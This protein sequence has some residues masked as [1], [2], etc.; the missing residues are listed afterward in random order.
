LKRIPVAAALAVFL[1]L[2]ARASWVSDDAFI[3]LRTVDNTLHGYG[4]RWNVDERVQVFTHPLWFL[5][6]THVCAVIPD[7]Y[8]AALAAGMAATLA[9][10]AVLARRFASRDAAIAAGL[11]GALALSR[12]F[13]DFSTSGLENP[14]THLLI[15]LFAMVAL[16]EGAWD[17]K[18][19]A[20]A[21]LLAGLLATNRMDALLIVAPTLVLR[22]WEARRQRPAAVVIAGF[23]PFLIWEAFAV[24]YY[25]SPWPNPAFAKLGAGIPSGELTGQGLLYLADAAWHDPVS[26]VLLVGGVLAGVASR[27]A[28]RV[29]LSFGIALETVY[30]VRV[31]GDFMSGRFLTAPALLGAI[32][33]ADRLVRARAGVRVAVGALVLSAGVLR[34]ASSGPLAAVGASGIAD[35]R[36]FYLASGGLFNGVAGWSRPTLA[37]PHLNA[38]T[39]LRRNEVPL[40]VEKAVGVVGDSAGPGVHIVDANAITD[41]FLA[42]LPAARVDAWRIG[43]FTRNVPAGYLATI[44]SGQNRLADP[45]LAALWDDM[46]RLTRGPLFTSARWRTIIARG[47]GGSGVPF[48][49]PT[50]TPV[51]WAELA[52]PGPAGA[53][54]EYRQALETAAAGDDGDA[55]R[56]LES[57]LAAAPDHERA[58]VLLARL[59]VRRGDVEGAAAPIARAREIAP[60]DPEAVRVAAD[61]AARAGRDAEAVPLWKRAA[62]L[63]PAGAGRA[64]GEIGR[65][66]ARGGDLVAALAWRDA[67]LA[68]SPG[69]PATLCVV[70]AIDELAQRPAEARAAYERALA[71][72]PAFEPAARA[73]RARSAR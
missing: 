31:G 45:R 11:V 22:L 4:P 64:Y 49:R 39:D 43:H 18:R 54:S 14:L 3:T 41:P 48:D 2:V 47:L 35:E 7:P 15:V 65:I 46:V 1:V 60:L 40:T 32:L 19:L 51:P 66:A 61:V 63:D 62:E 25:G 38:G 71:I 33:L 6:L 72:D 17:R 36:R 12:A 23:A 67:A 73:L 42:R 69:D 34:W 20:A 24:V 21:A 50:P 30:V 37:D 68:V 58:L 8:Y 5:L 56:R 59:R 52:G 10:T 13:V 26:I 70:G 27:S 9:A 29:A 57:C 55:E 53:E 44:A 28:A 16:E